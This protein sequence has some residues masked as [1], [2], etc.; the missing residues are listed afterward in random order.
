MS[1]QGPQAG[2]TPPLGDDFSE[3]LTFAFDAHVDQRRKGGDLPYIGHLLGVC[4]LVLEEGGD[5]E[6]AIAA[7]LHD[8][9][10]DQGGQP[11]LDEIRTR[12]G[13]GVADIV[14]ACSDTLVTPKPPWPARKQEYLDHLESQPKQILLVSLAD[15]LF[16]ARAIRRDYISEGEN[17]WRRFKGK[18]DPRT[19]EEVREDQLWYYEELAKRFERLSADVRMTRE[20]VEVI[21][22]LRRRVNASGSDA[23]A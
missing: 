14:L 12:F 20:L 4:S 7:L 2:A 21:E 23:H 5:E 13:D 22:D 19:L 8:A 10:E 17:L 15:K 11:M 18:H 3:A 9:V 6:A 16:N 1:S